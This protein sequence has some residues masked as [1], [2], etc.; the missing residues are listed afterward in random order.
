MN[1]LLFLISPL[2]ILCHGAAVANQGQSLKNADSQQPLLNSKAVVAVPILAGLVASASY[3]TLANVSWP[4]PF[5]ISDSWATDHI[6]GNVTIGAAIQDGWDGVVGSAREMAARIDRKAKNW[7]R[8]VIGT[9]FDVQ[10]SFPDGDSPLYQAIRKQV[11]DWHRLVNGL[12]ANREFIQNFLFKAL[13]NMI[14]YILEAQTPKL[15]LIIRPGTEF[16]I[17]ELST[18]HTNLKELHEFLQMLKE[19]VDPA[20]APSVLRL[21][22]FVQKKNFDLMKVIL[23]LM[24]RADKQTVL[25]I[26]RIDKE[27]PKAVVLDTEDIRQIDSALASPKDLYLVLFGKN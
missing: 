4:N 22:D 27:R 6:L 23:A 26:D 19:S 13:P 21:V 17:Q 8:S 5:Q 9:Q 7:I 1:L 11:Q 24:M 20:V 3:L 25:S 18:L 15:E 14:P 12:M 10:L 16:Q 2:P